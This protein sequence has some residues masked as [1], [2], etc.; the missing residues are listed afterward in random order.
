MI[1]IEGRDAA[2][3]LQGLVTNQISRIE[4]GGDGIFCA[5]LTAQGR[6]LFDAFIYPKNMA[7]TFPHP[8]YL[9]EHD[10]THTSALLS[11]L[12]RYKLRSKLTFQNVSEGY[13]VYQMW[14]PTSDLLWGS[15]VPPA[16]GKTLPQGSVLP[17]ERFCDV[18]CRDPRRPEMGLRVVVEKEKGLPTLPSTFQQVPLE[19]YTL[20]RILTGIP[21]GAA[22]FFSGTSL[23]LESNL[24]LISGVDFRK[25]CY[26]GQE[27][28]IRTYHTGITR[29]RIMPVQFYREDESPPDV[30]SVD[31]TTAY[32]TFAPQTDI[33]LIST[34]SSDPS[35][36]STPSPRRRRPHPPGKLCSTLHNVGLA[37]LRLDQ[38]EGATLGLENGWR[39]KPFAP[40]W[41][42]KAVEP[43]AS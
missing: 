13:A 37:L 3:F 6:I 33:S 42:P 12:T 16:A 39:V 29:K 15:F 23:P 30:L 31:T 28:T 9:I 11:H 40:S 36:D 21:E 7:D 8:S 5:F 19:K 25:G 2:K 38:L 35:T 10:A 32:P 1:Q 34:T 43:G 24:D 18:G 27:L 4:H 41:W 20:R 22:D 26:L 17:K 14:G